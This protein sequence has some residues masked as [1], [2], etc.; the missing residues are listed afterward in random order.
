MAELNVETRIVLGFKVAEDILEKL[1]PLGW[2]STPPEAGPSKGANLNVI[3]ADRLLVQNAD[4]LPIDGQATNQLAVIAVPARH[5]VSNAQGVL[6]VFGLSS[7][8]EGTPGPYGVFAPADVIC[9]R[10]LTVS[11]DEKVE[12]NENWDFS[13]ENGSR[14]GVQLQFKRGVPT[15]SQTETKAFS[16]KNPSFY[17]IYRADQGA[18]VLY[19]KM[20]NVNSTLIEPSY[21]VSF[22]GLEPSKDKAELISIISLPWTVR[23][24]FL[25]QL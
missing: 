10:G 7:K 25:P 17:R 5:L 6:I 12:V 3:F 9:E 13:G 8:A 22:L 19:S 1:L 4:G 2:Q 15:R 11:Q 20:N 24:A 16:Y 23:R 21:Q 18:D 14:I